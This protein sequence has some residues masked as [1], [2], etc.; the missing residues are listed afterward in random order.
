MPATRSVSVAAS[1]AVLTSLLLD[2]MVSIYI[3]AKKYELISIAP[4]V[5]HQPVNMF[6]IHLP[7]GGVFLESWLE[8]VKSVPRDLVLFFWSALR[9]C[10]VGKRCHDRF[11]LIIN[12]QSGD[13]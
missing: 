5:L 3:F 12:T 10:L 7:N 13:N 4:L 11:T 8:G 2:D 1:R 9:D 6:S